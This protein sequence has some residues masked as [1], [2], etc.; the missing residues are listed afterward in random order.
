MFSV[1][2]TEQTVKPFNKEVQKK[3][4]GDAEVITCRPADLLIPE[5]SRLCEKEMAQ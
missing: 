4:I 5:S 2:S 1:V 3:C